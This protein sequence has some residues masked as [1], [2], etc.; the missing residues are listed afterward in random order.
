MKGFVQMQV[1]T[2]SGTC[3]IANV[4]DVIPTAA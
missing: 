4:Y 3:G 2:G 1:G